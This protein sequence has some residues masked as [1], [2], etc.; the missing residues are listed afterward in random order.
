VLTSLERHAGRLGYIYGPSGKKTIAEGKD[1]TAIKYIMGTGGAL[2]RLPDRVGIL[3]NTKSA[4]NGSELYPGKNAEILIDNQYI[5]ASLGV[6]SKRYP[7][8]ALK[9]LLKSIGME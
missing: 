5:M 1:L 4:G 9:L 6:L 3:E 8:A 2:T 7:D